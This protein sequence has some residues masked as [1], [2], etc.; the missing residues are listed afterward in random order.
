[1][2]T[3]LIRSQS[4]GEANSTVFTQTSD[5]KCSAYSEKGYIFFLRLLILSP[6]NE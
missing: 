6:D 4:V 2:G 3:D 1:M 5:A